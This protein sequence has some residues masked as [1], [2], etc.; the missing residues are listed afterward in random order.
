MNPG[1]LINKAQI[2]PNDTAGSGYLH[3]LKKDVN[4]GFGALKMMLEVELTNG[5]KAILNV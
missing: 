1:K 5:I 4:A 3:R 2:E